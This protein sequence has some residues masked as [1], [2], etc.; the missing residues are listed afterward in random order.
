MRDIHPESPEGKHPSAH[1]A[2]Q[3]VSSCSFQNSPSSA[4]TLGYPASY[5][6]KDGI[7]AAVPSPLTQSG[8]Y[9]KPPWKKDVVLPC[10]GMGFW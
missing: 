10:S 8:A 4:S 7:I 6:H 1:S 3:K 9:Q 5:K 2:C